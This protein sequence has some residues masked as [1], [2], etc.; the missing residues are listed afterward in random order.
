MGL[1]TDGRA[2][3]LRKTSKGTRMAWG[4]VTEI[5]IL[6]FLLRF[7]ETQKSGIYAAQA[8]LPLALPITLPF[9]HQC[10]DIHTR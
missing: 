4:P 9:R 2:T 3:I 10:V 7:Y 6:V 5:L 1:I 8:L